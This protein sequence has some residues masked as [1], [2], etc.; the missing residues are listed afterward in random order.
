MWLAGSADSRR[1]V[2]N[3]LYYSVVKE[4]RL[5]SVTSEETGMGFLIPSPDTSLASVF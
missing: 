5:S 1:K 4:Q 3:M 2:K